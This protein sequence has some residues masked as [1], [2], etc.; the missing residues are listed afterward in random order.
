MV[1]ALNDGD[2]TEMNTTRVEKKPLSY[3]IISKL[4]HN[5]ITDRLGYFVIGT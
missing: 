3:I 2:R 5:L 4:A 1:Q